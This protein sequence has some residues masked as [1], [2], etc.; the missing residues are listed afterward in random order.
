MRKLT[1]TFVLLGALALT[2]I[3]ALAGFAS[4]FSPVAVFGTL[5]PKDGGVSVVR[6][7]AYGPEP[8]QY[9]DVYRP[10]GEASGLPVIFFSYGGGW[11]SGEKADYGFVGKAFAARGYVVVIADYRVVPEVVY[12]AF[13][14]DNA[15]AVRWL[16]QEIS[17]YGGDPS[18]LFLMG[19]SAGAYNVMMLALSDRFGVDTSAIDGV[20]GLSGP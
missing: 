19:H 2:I 10:D 3:G 7:I 5:V 1:R 20:V 17:A 15:R 4:A 14:E 11:E 13:V 9:L 16:Q 8:R 6:D 18:R 12:P